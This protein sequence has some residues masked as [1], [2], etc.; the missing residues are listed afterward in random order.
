VAIT[1]FTEF[2]ELHEQIAREVPGIFP[3]K[4]VNVNVFKSGLMIPVRDQ[5][6]Q[7]IAIRFR[8]DNAGDGNKYQCFTS[9]FKGKNKVGE[10]YPTP[11]TPCHFSSTP[12]ASEAK[13]IRLTEGDLKADIASQMTSIPTISVSGVGTWQNA[14]ETIES[15]G[16]DRLLLSFDA[17]AATNEAVA[18][19]LREAWGYFTRP[20]STITPEIETW[21]AT[22][23]DAGKLQPKGIDDALVA[24]ATIRTLAGDEARAFIASLQIAPKNP[25]SSVARKSPFSNFVIEVTEEKNSK[26]ETVETRTKCGLPI[27]VIAKKLLS[28]TGG[29]P[30]F[31]NDQLFIVQDERVERFAKSSNLFSWINDASMCTWGR[32]ESMPTKEEFFDGLSRHCERYEAIEAYPHFPQMAD[33]YYVSPVSPSKGTDV[34]DEF[35][36]F[37]K[38]AKGNAGLLRAALLTLFWGGS[39]GS[40]PLFLITS[41]HGTGSGKSK[42]AELFASLVGTPHN[43]GT[44]TDGDKI[45]TDLLTP[46]METARTVIIDNV[47]AKLSSEAIESLVTSS[48]IGGHKNY[49]GSASRP[50]TMIW[51]ITANAATLSRD[52]AQRSIVVKV[53][54]PDYDG[55]WLSNVRN[56]IKL[57]RERIYADVAY[58]FS[59][60]AA[61]ISPASRWAEWETDVLARCNDPASLQTVIGK[62]GGECDADG[63][64]AA[65]IESVFFENLK[66]AGYKP[67]KHVVH[68]P[69]NL[70]A[71]WLA[72]AFDEHV[73]KSSVSRT[74]NLLHRSGSLP[75]ISINPSKNCGRGFIWRGDDSDP[76]ESV[77]YELE[78]IISGEA[79]HEQDAN[80]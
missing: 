14:I 5:S 53:D 50:N 45:R 63:D 10:F 47:K 41:D 1:L 60:A 23:D 74:I 49:H 55:Q 26:G 59:Q 13:T 11:G 35:L 61:G 67:E 31:A 37:F 20:E 54:K 9:Q 38:P 15:S 30:K 34:L 8:P 18:K 22:M 58:V 3:G 72:I 33:H 16:Y 39:P 64:R 29:W 32:G 79:K 65:E 46:G 42:V 70:A 76:K 2:R 57:N 51:F 62:Q 40:R 7:M 24:G 43:F 27:S 73:G 44:K 19:V 28:Q 25:T 17:D 71:N 69:N 56:F 66:L 77:N 48:T 4:A 36:A 12:A 78:S 21:P 68:V 52:L 75:R 80:Q 6:G